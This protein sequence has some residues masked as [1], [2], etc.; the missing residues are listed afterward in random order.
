MTTDQEYREELR[1]A[2]GT[3]M[4]VLHAG[5]V[6]GSGAPG[7]PAGLRLRAEELLA[8][9]GAVMV[10][11]L[12]I[13][14][15]EEFHRS[16]DRFGDRLIRSYRGGNTP[17]VAVSDQ[18][19]QWHPSNRPEGEGRT[20]LSLIESADDLPHWVTYRDGSPIPDEDL[21]RC[22]RPRGATGCRCPGAAAA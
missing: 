1:T 4:G 19:D 11:G 21:A 13:A 5:A 9:H 12:G 17:R 6:A 16:V 10:H 14:D 18:A 22:G 20:L 3:S 15:A 2:G 7:A 8:E